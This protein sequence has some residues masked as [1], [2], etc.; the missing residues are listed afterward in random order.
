MYLL[1]STITTK[2]AAARG[3]DLLAHHRAAPSLDE[4]QRGVD[5]VGAVDRDVEAVGAELLDHDAV[6][7]APASALATDVATARIVRPCA[8][9]LG[10]RRR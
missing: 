2:R 4:A 6:L 8:N 3:D 7:A 5:A 9:P 10:E 1:S